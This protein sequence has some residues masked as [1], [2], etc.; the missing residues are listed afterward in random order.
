MLWVCVIRPR[1]PGL[2]AGVKISERRRQEKPGGP[3]GTTL[4]PALN[5][6]RT[7][8]FASRDGLGSTVS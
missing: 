2:G 8:P 1:Y 7:L 6:I 5:T 3:G 4:R